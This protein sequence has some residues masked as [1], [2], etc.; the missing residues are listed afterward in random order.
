MAEEIRMHGTQEPINPVSPDVIALDLCESYQN[1][2]EARSLA[3]LYRMASE[4][5]LKDFWTAV[6]RELETSIFAERESGAED[7]E[8]EEII[9]T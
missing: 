5:E 3:G 7:W 4:G 2:F 6:I 9:S 8:D 1:I